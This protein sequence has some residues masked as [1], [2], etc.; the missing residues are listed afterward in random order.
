MRCTKLMVIRHA[1]KPDKHAGAHGVTATGVP[2]RY[3]LTSRGW[4]RA[5]AL[6][7]LFNPADKDRLPVGLAVPGAIFAA[8][9]SEDYPSKRSL[10][11]VGP[12]ATYLGLRVRTEFEPHQERDLIAAALDAST[13]V[14][15]CWHH[16]RIPKLVAGLGVAIDEWPESVFDRVLILDRIGERWSLRVL[17][18]RLLPDDR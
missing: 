17:A 18:Q 6:V 4:Q 3:E 14:L 11:T 5:M 13:A 15:I 16:R 8:P 2:D 10:H 12:L 7:H 9:A 1:E